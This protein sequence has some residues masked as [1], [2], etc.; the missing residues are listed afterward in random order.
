[1]RLLLAV[2]VYRSDGKKQIS[3]GQ[4]LARDLKIDVA[5]AVTK[6]QAVLHLAHAHLVYLFLNTKCEAML[7]MDDD[8][9]CESE[10]IGRMLASNAGAIVAPYLV[11]GSDPERFDTNLLP[12]GHVETAGLGLALVRRHVLE[13]LWHGF[14]EELGCFDD[15]GRELVCFFRDFFGE[16]NG[17]RKLLRHD[18]AFWC[19]VRAAGF[20][21]EALD[22]ATTNHAGETRT[23]Q[24]EVLT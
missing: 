14:R 7:M 6:N 1:V 9:T 18:H 23:Y 12:S 16:R 4:K 15:D 21:I 17:K 2:P 5:I 22:N 10:V 13:R 20:N 8:V 19:R 11:R 3:F 24:K